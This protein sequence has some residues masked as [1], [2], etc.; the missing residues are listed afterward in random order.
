MRSIINLL[1]VACALLLIAYVVPGISIA[2]T[3]T[4]F[5]VAIIWGFI[6][7]FIKPVLNILTLPITIL[8]LGLFSLI[9]NALLFW[10]LSTFIAGFS[11]SGF[12]PALI[13]SFILSVVVWALHKIW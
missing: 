6:S 1:V 9:I 2:S 5:I 10:F 11:V 13:G 7:L 3:Y 12:L 4:A 8:T